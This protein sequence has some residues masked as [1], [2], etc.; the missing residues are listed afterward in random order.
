[1]R[2]NP[3]EVDRL[4][5]R[6]KMHLGSTGMALVNFVQ[7]GGEFSIPEADE[8]AV[9]VHEIL[10]QEKQLSSTISNH[11]SAIQSIL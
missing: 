3:G 11:R 7:L 1:M 4:S 8:I 10:V 2:G 9:A 6:H 5:H